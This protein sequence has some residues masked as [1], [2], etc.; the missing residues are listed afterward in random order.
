[1]GKFKVGTHEFD[2]RKLDAFSQMHI[3][4]RLSPLV[5]GI[6][7]LAELDFSKLDIRKDADGALAGVSFE[8][9]AASFVTPLTDALA[10][11]K[12]E[13]V[14]YICN[15][16]LAVTS[17][18]Q[19]GSWVPLMQGEQLMFPDFGMIEILGIAVNVLTENLLNFT[20]GQLSLS[21]LADKLGV[22]LPG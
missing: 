13:D 4:R 7:R 2:S 14:E 3:T 17:Y 19:K 1:M 9:D 6:V 22:K 21:S 10:S 15:K 5:G 11:L 12:D 16:C 20:N 18:R 8:G